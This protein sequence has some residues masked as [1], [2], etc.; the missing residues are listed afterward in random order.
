MADAN[1]FPSSLS[2][3]TKPPE[4]AAFL[5]MD[6]EIANAS[7]T[8][9]DALGRP[10]IKGL[11][12]VDITVPSDRERV[13]SHQRQ[14]QDEQKMREPT[15]L[16]P[17]FGK[18]E[19]DRVIQ[20]LGF[21]P[22]EI[23]RYQLDRHE[24]L[25]FQTADGQSRTFPVRMGLAKQDSIYFVVVSLNL[26][27]R[28]FQP[29]T[30]SPNPRD[31]MY[32]YQALPQPYSQPTPVSATFDPRSTRGREGAYGQRQLETPT[33]MMVGLSPGLGPS[34][35]ASPSRPDYPAGQPSYQVPRSELP[36]ATR[37]PQT[38]GYQLPPIRSQ[39]QQQSA[40]PPPLPDPSPQ[41]RE[42]RSRVD[43]GGLID[44]TDPSRRPHQ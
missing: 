10:N 3:S 23:S 35:A 1:V 26:A 32:S 37:P 42:D 20:A 28:Q 11:K 15:Y 13:L 7:T 6:L 2:I 16:P 25:T 33:Q 29:P 36:P 43:I 5:T 41:G 22:E 12:L 24:Y 38:P 14:M 8:F 18:Q 31:I 21:S 4:P 17:I 39:Q 34:Y 30:P 9:V 19:E 27:V 40:P 44:Q